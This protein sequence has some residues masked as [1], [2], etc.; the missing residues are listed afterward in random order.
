MFGAASKPKLVRNVPFRP[1]DRGPTESMAVVPVF[2]IVVIRSSV[3]LGTELVYVAGLNVKVKI[4]V[5][6]ADRTAI[7]AN[8]RRKKNL[9]TIGESPFSLQIVQSRI[10]LS[11]PRVY[12]RTIKY[13]F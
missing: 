12:L 5:A 9:F 6:L 4:G 3:K 11:L 13:R 1:N 8:R 2:V 10:F 7:P